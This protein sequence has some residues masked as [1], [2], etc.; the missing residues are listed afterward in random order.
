MTYLTLVVILTFQ[1]K[2][3]RALRLAENL[4]YP[5]FIFILHNTNICP[6]RKTPFSEAGEI[7]LFPVMLYTWIFLVNLLEKP[8][9][10][11]NYKSNLSGAG[12]FMNQSEHAL[13]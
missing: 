9:F 10:T 12:A 13:R 4:V 11:L 6:L 8:A 5:V 7:R 1:T 3:M 2:K